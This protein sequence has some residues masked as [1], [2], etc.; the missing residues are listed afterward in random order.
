MRLRSIAFVLYLAGLAFTGTRDQPP[1][2]RV[3][4]SVSHDGLVERNGFRLFY[5]VIG[6]RGP[7]IIVLAGGPG[8][9]PAYL[10]PVVDGMKANYQCVL[11]EQRGT[12]RSTLTRYDAQTINF[13]EYLQDLEALRKQLNQSKLLLVGHSWGGMLA[14][15]YAGTYPRQVRGVVAIDSG[16]IAEEHAIAEESN[17]L[18]RLA[19]QERDQLVEWQKR[20]SRE[21]ARAFGEIQRLE[22]PAYF[23]DPRKLGSTK[24]WLTT[25]ANLEVMRL[26]YQP[27]FGSLDE[28]IRSRLH[29]IS[30]PVLLIHGRQDAVAEGGV[31]EAHR[32]I[33]GSKLVLLNECGH[34][35]WIEQPD[36]MWRAVYSFLAAI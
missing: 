1:A 36:P 35:P 12:G 21:P 19:A 31:S 33:K 27:Q 6:D 11:L 26:G 14:L 28:F 23:Y 22:L 29:S 32:L 5:R 20:A 8:G 4:G 10:T 18:R 9:D 25:G 3:S 16:P 13:A 7:V 2:K 15:S 34:M 17:V 24:T 30:A